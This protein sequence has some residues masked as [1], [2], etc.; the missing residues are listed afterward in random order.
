M[1]VALAEQGRGGELAQVRDQ[2][3]ADLEVEGERQAHGLF[4]ARV[5]LPRRATTLP[6]GMDDN[7]ALDRRLTIYGF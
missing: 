1:A 7:G 4:Q 6:V 2:G 3:F 5:R